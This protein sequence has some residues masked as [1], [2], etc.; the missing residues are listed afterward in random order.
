MNS[1]EPGARGRKNGSEFLD[2][3]LLYLPED[4][5]DFECFVEYGGQ[6]VAGEEPAT[7]L[8][9]LLGLETKIEKLRLEF[10]LLCR[11]LELLADFA[12]SGSGEWK[13]KA[14]NEAIFALIYCAKECDL[15]PDSIPEI[16]YSDDAIV[17]Q[18]VLARNAAI[19]EAHC[20]ARG[21]DWQAIAGPAPVS[22]TSE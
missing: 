4:G 15:I 20:D 7:L 9:V 13:E 3:Y 10:P 6:L 12:V 19:L 2:G 18:L 11:Q 5:L 1:I 14:R 16:G 17:T 8:S 22:E 21:V